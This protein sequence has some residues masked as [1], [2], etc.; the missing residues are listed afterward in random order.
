MGV[1][2]ALFSVTTPHKPHFRDQAPRF[3]EFCW[4]KVAMVF[5]VDKDKGWVKDF[6][7]PYQ[8]DMRVSETGDLNRRIQWVE[9]DSFCQDHFLKHRMQRDLYSFLFSE[10]VLGTHTYFWRITLKYW[11]PFTVVIRRIICELERNAEHITWNIHKFNIRI[12]SGWGF[13]LKTQIK[14]KYKCK[15]IYLRGIS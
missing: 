9:R 13:S 10:P 15:Y 14:S 6:K 2:N 3:R 7:M 5:E 1:C 11:H 4:M 12:H 8:R